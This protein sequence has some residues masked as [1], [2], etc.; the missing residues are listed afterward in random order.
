M[1]PYEAVIATVREIS[2]RLNMSEIVFPPQVLI[3]MLE[4]YAFEHQRGVGSPTWVMDLFIEIGVPFETLVSVL[5]AM[6]YNN[7]APFEGKNRRVIAKDMLYAIQNWYQ[8]CARSN[9]HLFGGE[10]NAATISQT[11]LMLTQNGL[12]NAEVREA[13]DLRLKIERGFR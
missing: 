2:Y 4:R 11:L 13:Q 3:P 6:F 12:E 1:K 9:Q 8:Q 7:E 10:D 5:E